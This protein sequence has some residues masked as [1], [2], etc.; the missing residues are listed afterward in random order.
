MSKSNPPAITRDLSVRADLSITKDDLVAIRVAEVEKALHQEK[1]DCIAARA[2]AVE[3]HQLAVKAH[4][5][6]LQEAGDAAFEGVFEDLLA[7]LNAFVPK[8]SDPFALHVHVEFDAKLNQYVA[9]GG[10]TKVPLN[11]DRLPSA[12]HQA[13]LRKTQEAVDA[14]AKSIRA[15]EEQML[16][17]KRRLA[18]IPALE[19]QVKAAVARAVIGT[20]DDNGAALLRSVNGITLPGLPGP[21]A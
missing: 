9:H 16:D 20:T 8:G 19:R 12:R 18:D 4:E 6:A 13:N 21:K 11:L 10:I 5:L 1:M 15:C 14:A 3:A 2:A 17:I 7:A